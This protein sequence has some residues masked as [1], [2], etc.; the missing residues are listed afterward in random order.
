MELQQFMQDKAGCYS[1]T[2]DF[3]V[4][5]VRNSDFLR[6]ID[7]PD[8]HIQLFITRG[9]INATINGRTVILRSDSLIDV[10][11]HKF[12][13]QEATPDISVIF[14]FAT[15]T[16]FVH[17]MKNRPPFPIEYVMQ[18]LNYPVLLLSHDQVSVMRERFNLLLSM[19][20]D[21]SNYHQSEMTKCALWMIYLE[22][23]NIFMHEK[24]ESRIPQETDR[25]HILFM[26]FVKTLPLYIKQERSVKFYASELCVSCQ[27]L[28]R[29]V[30]LISGETAYQWIQRSLTGEINRAL[31]DTDMS[32]Q[33]IATEFGFPDQSTFTKYY[34]RNEH[35]TPSEYRTSGISF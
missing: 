15:E 27:Y 26:K 31:K 6:D 9:S 4:W 5:E 35:T 21:T 25:K 29:I 16:F 14:I 17:L 11:H 2:S 13:I 22:M 8:V 32:I 33:Q 3:Y 1:D 18:I 23:S 34:R 7:M 19:L 10:L 12:H 30:K 28:E 24:E 20:K